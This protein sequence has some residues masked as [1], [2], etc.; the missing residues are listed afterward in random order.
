MSAPT[1]ETI[2][3]WVRMRNDHRYLSYEIVRGDY[4]S[5]RAAFGGCSLALRLRALVAAKLKFT[6]LCSL[7]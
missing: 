2:P 5:L 3:G 7:S 6:F 1:A 4:D